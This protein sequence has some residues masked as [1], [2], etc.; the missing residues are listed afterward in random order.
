[1][2]FSLV[3]LLH[4]DSAAAGSVGGRKAFAVW[5]GRQLRS[6]YDPRRPCCDSL[7]EMNEVDLPVARRFVDPGQHYFSDQ[8]TSS[9]EGPLDPDIVAASN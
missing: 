2:T 5:S 7:C 3:C 6:N 8:K 9:L 1:M 4:V